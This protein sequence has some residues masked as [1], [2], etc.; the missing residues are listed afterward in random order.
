MARIVYTPEGGSKQ[1]WEFDAENPDWDVA[2]NTE[3]VTGW[4]W[5][6]FS[7]RLANGSFIAL[8]ALVFTLRKRKEKG[9]TLASVEV[10]FNDISIE[11]DEEPEQ[12]EEPEG[13]A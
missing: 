10:T 3:K 4:P 1:E 5:V 6:E 11:E 2:Y 12:E 13:K 9:I 8:Q 7:E